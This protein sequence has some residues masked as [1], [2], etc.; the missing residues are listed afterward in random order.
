Q[1]ARPDFA[2]TVSNARAVEEL[3]RRLEGIPL[4]LELAAARANVMSPAQML[5]QLGRR[6][7]FFVNRQR[8]T[9]ARHRTLRSA[10]EWSYHL[11]SAEGQRFFARLSVF[12]GGWTAGAAEA[13]CEE[14]LA[15]DYLA[16]LRDA[17]LI[18]AEERGEE[19]R[20]RMLETVREY[21]M[22]QLS[23]EE[24]ADVER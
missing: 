11:L 12:R 10:M 6:L 24:R 1:M 8:D 2:L 14:P 13:V 20:F 18:L 5:G 9:I 23:E 22:E 19:M 3:C 17:S 16:Q 7:D 15:V 4:A 21:A